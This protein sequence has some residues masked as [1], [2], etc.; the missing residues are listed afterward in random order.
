M[1]EIIFLLGGLVG[2]R[3]FEAWLR[4]RA[5]STPAQ[6]GARLWYYWAVQALAFTALAFVGRFSPIL[7]AIALC[8]WGSTIYQFYRQ[9]AQFSLRS[10][11]LVTLVVAAVCSASYYVT[12]AVLIVLLCAFVATWIQYRCGEYNPAGNTFGAEASS[13][14]RVSNLPRIMG[15]AGRFIG[16][17][18]RWA[19]ESRR[20]T[21]ALCCRG[22]QS[23]NRV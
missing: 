23:S 9:R 4:S 19:R 21:I 14:T 17:C 8:S 2:L 13:Q 7:A 12:A 6:R 3:L 15:A 16:G 10:M 1:G 20:R 5:A 22:W 18:I 11:C